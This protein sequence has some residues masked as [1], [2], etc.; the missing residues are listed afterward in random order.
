MNVVKIVKYQHGY[1]MAVRQQ[2]I[3]NQK[4]LDGHRQELNSLIK[5]QKIQRKNAESQ[6]V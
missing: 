2:H 1:T 4:K 5:L 3:Q 6:I